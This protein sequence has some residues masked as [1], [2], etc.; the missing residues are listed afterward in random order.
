[1]RTL[2]IKQEIQTK[3]SQHLLLSL[4][5]QQAFH[6][7][8]MPIL[9]LSEW[10]KLEIE[11]NPILELDSSQEEGKESLE[12]ICSE[13]SQ[14]PSEYSDQATEEYEK[15]RK[16]YQDSLLTHPIS[17]YEHLVIQ[18]RFAFDC[19]QD[20][21]TAEL[22]IG[23]L[24]QRGFLTTP[25][26]QINPAASLVYLYSILS[27]IQSFDPP[28]IAAVNLQDSLLLQLRLKNKENTLA[29]RIVKERLEDL[30]H[31]RL[32]VIC[33]ALQI[34][35]KTLR[36]IV[37]SDITPLDLH[38]G[39]RFHDTYACPIIPDIQF[40]YREADLQGEQSQEWFIHIN[41]SRLPRFSI[42]PCYLKEQKLEKEELLFLQHHL[43][44][45]KW[46]KKIV[47]RRQDTLRSI[48]TYLIKKQSSFLNGEQKTLHPMTIQEMAQELGM[49]E[50]TV[51]RAVS[52]KHIS[53]P[54]GMFALRSFFTH[55]ITCQNGQK[56][57]NHTLRQLL[58]QM[59][60]REDKNSP[61]S[62]AAIADQFKKMGIPC[63]RRTVS[64]YRERLQIAPSSR[65]RT[66]I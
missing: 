49:H 21:A 14:E 63:A 29:Y 45:A 5:M 46:L 23:H 32:P 57:S 42:A 12:E 30:L 39:Y 58:A 20:L 1:M 54:Q 62:D 24:D 25:L 26:E 2:S 27:V 61:L 47:K 18:A 43:T 4:A 66:W 52:N 33:T 9:A 44:N 34:P 35:I 17:L 60:E 55:S 65:R 7:L 48:A 15:K 56:V 28:G 16:A 64:K 22:I 19:P 3:Q 50:S 40:D 38:P 13:L 36:E 41:H 10:L 11:Q 8:Q 53:C 51:A 37:R 59:V 31:N 6:V